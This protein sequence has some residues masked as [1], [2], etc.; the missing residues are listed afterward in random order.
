VALA[1]LRLPA[2]SAGEKKL[3]AVDASQCA[4]ARDAKKLE[5]SLARALACN[6]ARLRR[7]AAARCTPSEPPACAGALVEDAAGLAY[8]AAELPPVAVDPDALGPQLACQAAIGRATARYAAVRLA[9]RAAGRSRADADAR[10][11]GELEDLFAACDVALAQDAQGRMLPAVGPRCGAA[12]GPPG[13]RVDVAAL[14]GCLASLLSAWVER[15]GPDPRPPRPNIVFVL[16]DDQRHDA[17]D[18]THAPPGV[19]VMP[20]VRRELAGEGL[21][22]TRAS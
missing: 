1:R 9:A 14:R 12:V 13:D 22:L 7:G 3:P 19:I 8:G 10:A 21:E 2:P 16:T 15:I 6:D 20:A 4:A 11:Q 5:K 17:T 18:G